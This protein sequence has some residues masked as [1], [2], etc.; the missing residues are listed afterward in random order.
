MNFMDRITGNDM[1]RAMQRMQEQVDQLPKEYQEAWLQIHTHIW[2]YADITGRN[3]IPVLEN[4]V[5]LLEVTAAD[6]SSVQ[7]V[8]GEDYK[9]FVHALVGGEDSKLYR[10]KWRRQL[11]ENVEKKLANL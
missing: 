11:N 3:L 10:D 4:I 1:K 8:F 5:E 6:Q 7:E 2:S 9:G